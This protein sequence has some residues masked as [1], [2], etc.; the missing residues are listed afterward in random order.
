MNTNTAQ[1]RKPGTFSMLALCAALGLALSAAAGAADTGTGSNA[2]FDS[3]VL[4]SLADG[5]L[6]VMKV[7]HQG[8]LHMSLRSPSQETGALYEPAVA[9]SRVPERGVHLS[10]RMPW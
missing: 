3:P 4:H 7:G 9:D 1:Q 8:G 10:F 6:Q 2:L 5:D